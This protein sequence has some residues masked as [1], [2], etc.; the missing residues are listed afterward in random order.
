MSVTICHTRR[1]S[2]DIHGDRDDVTRHMRRVEQTFLAL[3]DSLTS[4]AVALVDTT[5][6]EVYRD[7][8][9]ESAPKRFVSSAQTGVYCYGREMWYGFNTQIWSGQYYYLSDF[10]D[11]LSSS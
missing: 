6:S 3:T 11:S 10:F 2:K 1:V 4:A 9:G 7:R 5:E 8:L